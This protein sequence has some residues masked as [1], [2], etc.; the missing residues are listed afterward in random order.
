M[1]HVNI[2]DP[3]AEMF[4]AMQ[5]E[6]QTLKQE[7]AWLKQNSGGSTGNDTQSLQHVEQKKRSI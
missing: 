4:R 6:I 7:I 1:D 2:P 3:V 5:E